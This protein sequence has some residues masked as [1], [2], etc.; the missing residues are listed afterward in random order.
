MVEATVMSAVDTDENEL[1]FEEE[2]QSDNPDNT[3]ES[4]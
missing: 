3:V 4:K 2:Q 1:P